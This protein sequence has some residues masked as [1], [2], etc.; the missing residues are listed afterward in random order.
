MDEPIIASTTIEYSDLEVLRIELRE[1]P[2]K[3]RNFKI[4]IRTFYRTDYTGPFLPG[5]GCTLP[6]ENW[7]EFKAHV[8]KFDQMLKGHKRVIR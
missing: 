1:Y 7:G 2:P 6:I 5:K 3:S 4:H 8:K